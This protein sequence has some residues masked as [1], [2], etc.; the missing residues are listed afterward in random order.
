M[1][2]IE[3]T[4]NILNQLSEST[5]SITATGKIDIK[6]RFYS[7]ITAESLEHIKIQKT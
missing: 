7:I 1:F 3:K 2:Y 5:I 4:P 6:N